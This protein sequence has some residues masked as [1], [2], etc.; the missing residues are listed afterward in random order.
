MSPPTRWWCFLNFLNLPNPRE[1]SV[2]RR[3][4]LFA[5]LV[6]F[7]SQGSP[8]WCGETALVAGDLTHKLL[9]AAGCRHQLLSGRIV[10]SAAEELHPW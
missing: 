6:A 3:Y 1:L 2:G 5:H 4:I 8:G 10:I 7:P 9:K